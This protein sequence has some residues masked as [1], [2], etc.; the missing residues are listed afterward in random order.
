MNPFRLL[1]SCFKNI[2]RNRMRSLLTSLGIIIGVASVII[3]LAVGEGAQ[4][5]IE[6]RIAAMGTNLLQIMPRRI[7]PSWQV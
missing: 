4:K 5:A 6:S 2:A 1:K 3:M 7:I